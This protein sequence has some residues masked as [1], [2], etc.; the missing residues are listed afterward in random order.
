M[1]PPEPSY[2][3][4]PSSECSN[5]AEA[6]ENDLKSNLRKVICTFKEEINKSLK[7]I[8]ENTCK[9]MK[10]I[11]KTVQDLKMK[12]KV[13]KKAQ[14]QGILEK[15][16]LGKRTETAIASTIYIDVPDPE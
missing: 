3:T 6:Q 13:I 12:I 15:E 5:S 7:E 11:N 10:E 16:N 8:Q 9:Q 14:T 2:P 4:I 1:L